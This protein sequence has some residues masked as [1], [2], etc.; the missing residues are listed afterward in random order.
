MEELDPKPFLECAELLVRYDETNLALKLLDMLPAEYRDKM[1]V[2][3]YNLKK[4]IQSKI[5][6]PYDLLTDDRENPKSI[7]WSVQFL[8]TTARGLT[9]K[10]H[11]KDYNEKNKVPHIVEMGPG[12]FTFVSGLKE[13]GYKF[14]YDCFTLNLLAKDMASQRL[15]EN[16][17]PEDK[18][19]DIFVAYE[20]IE[21]LE[22]TNEIRKVWS[23]L[24]N[25]PE[26][27]LIS[28][29]KYCYGLGTPNW[30]KD[31]IH[32]LRAYT[33]REFQVEV[34]KMFPEYQFT[35]VDNEVMVLSGKLF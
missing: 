24:K 13:E 19:T 17:G 29:P 22:D 10:S 34:L 26:Y 4:E 16:W 20:I 30:R 14:T 32:H 23:R 6:L 3:I 15:G 21:H 33:P 1:P 27:V 18:E 28:T 7:E 9:L 11:I 31:G 35:F 8:N 25:T 2:V 5:T 12:D